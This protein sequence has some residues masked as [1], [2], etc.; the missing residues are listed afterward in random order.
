MES[1]VETASSARGLPQMVIFLY[2]DH[3]HVDFI[4][5]FYMIWESGLL[6]P[7]KYIFVKHFAGYREHK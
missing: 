5:I 1:F 2:P 4:M 6:S 7:S 3:M